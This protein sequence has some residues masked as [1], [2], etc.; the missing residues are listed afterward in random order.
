MILGVDIGGTSS[1][2]LLADLDGTRLGSGRTGGGNPNSHAPAQAAAE[3]AGALK[4]AL[5]GRDPAGVVAA[6]VGMAGASKMSDPEIVALFTEMWHGV[7]LRCPLRVVT[8]CEVGFA[9]GTP[10]PNGAA[11]VAG[12]GSVAMRIVDHRMAAIFGGNGWLLG[13]EGSGYW[14]GREAVRATLK[15]VEGRAPLTALSRAVLAEVGGTDSADR[16][17]L[18]ITRCNADEPVRLAR[19]APLVSTAAA[20]GDEIAQD[21]VRRGV[22]HLVDITLAAAPAADDD[23]PVVLIGSLTEAGNP[24]GDALRVGLS[25]NGFCD[26]S[27]ATD[28]A[29]GAA[30]LAA[31]ELLPDEAQRRALHTALLA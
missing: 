19:F 1:R 11:L 12:T 8:D 21:I 17:R 26:I 29:A 7:G 10:K 20:E 5:D 31:T 27:E 30:W 9:A 25:A 16:R 4:A 28:G 13:D 2:A 6:V 18:V 22:L 3:V 15:A 23:S 14:V 24:F